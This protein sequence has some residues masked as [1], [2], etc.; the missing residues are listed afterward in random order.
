MCYPSQRKDKSGLKAAVVFVAAA[1][2]ATVLAL[3][4]H[5]QAHAQASAPAVQEPVTVKQIALGGSHACALVD[6]AEAAGI[7]YC[8]GRNDTKQIGVR[9]QPVPYIAETIAGLDSGVRAVAAGDRRTCV[10]TAEGGVVCW[11][12][13][14]MDDWGE[15]DIIDERPVAVEGLESGVLA[16]AMG[17]DMACA[18][19]DTRGV[20]CWYVGEEWPRPKEVPTLGAGV[21]AIDNGNEHTCVIMENGG[22]KCWGSNDHG[23]L[24]DGTQER[25]SEPVEVVGLGS[26]VMAVSAGTDHTCALKED[27]SVLCWGANA[28]GQVGDG[29][30]Q[31]RLAPVAISGLP[32]DVVAIAASDGFSCALSAT[33]TMCW[34]R[35]GSGQLGNGST[36]GHLTPTDAALPSGGLSIAVGYKHGCV[37]LAEGKDAQGFGRIRCWGHNEWG[38]LGANPGYQ[39]RSVDGLSGVM[40]VTGGGAHTCVLTD[41]GGVRCW[42]T[43]WSGQLGDGSTVT[44]FQPQDVSGLQV[45]VQTVDAGGMHTCALLTAGSVRCWGN[46]FYGQLGDG[47]KQDRLA[48][49]AVSGLAGSVD[50]LSVG[51]YDTC[52]LLDGSPW[53]WGLANGPVPVKVGGLGEQVQAILPGGGYMCAITQNGGSK[54]W[55]ANQYGQLGDGTYDKRTLPVD[56]VGLTGDASVRVAALSADAYHTCALASNGEVWCWGSNAA[57]Q[58][59]NGSTNDRS[60]TPHA[61]AALGSGV[62][63]I[64]AGGGRERWPFYW[65]SYAL[66]H[67]CA[68]TANGGVKC[69]GSN[70]T[71]QL[72]DGTL[73][74]RSLP[75]NVRGLE[76][77]VRAI[78]VGLLHNC[79][80]TSDGGV[81]CWG[82]N[83]SGQLGSNPG[84]LPVTV[85]GDT[86]PLLY[87]PRISG[88]R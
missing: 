19:T 55:G 76:Q 65:A 61:I 28:D 87:L 68:L 32:A 43:N 33:S 47:T 7:V 75:V 54:C 88:L 64:A 15:Y 1:F 31:D 69:W 58:L 27:G 12:W 57:G 16:L 77:G 84:W 36:E 17:G 21:R 78:A 13:A 20:L 26:G 73:S 56:V 70:T 72:G 59:G 49:V 38:Q 23:Q 39:P 35:N 71:G 46:N 85:T 41:A 10:L 79:V 24:G 5:G 48:P 83:E 53:C 9:T 11:G 8:W 74:D 29:T 63:I 80:V 51:R 14:G 2:A 4:W 45:G 60:S 18:L 86:P 66:G 22:V 34:G 37:L 81:Q 50:A 67:T 82:G 40:S 6:T 30:Q 42:G 52:V 25:R 62:R 44:R 3:A